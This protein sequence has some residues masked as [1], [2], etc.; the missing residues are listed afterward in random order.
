MLI[1]VKANVTRFNGNKKRKRQETYLLQ[2]ELFAE[3]EYAVTALLHG[4]QAGKAVVD[5]EVLS[6]RLSPIKEIADQFSGQHSYIATL[7]DIF[8][9][10]EG[11]EKALRY[12]VLLWADSLAAATRRAGELQSEGYDMQVEGIKEV[13]YEFLH[14]DA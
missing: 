14:D 6:L 10:D 3:A 11:N 7:K 4:Q 12:K 13:N 1:E 9:D 5:F 2:R 8:H